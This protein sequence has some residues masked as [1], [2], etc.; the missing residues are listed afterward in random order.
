[1]HARVIA[2]WDSVTR[3]PLK[4]SGAGRR[5]TSVG[6]ILHLSDVHLGTPRGY[7]PIDEAKKQ[8]PGIDPRTQREVLEETLK[9]LSD[10]EE[11]RKSVDA[12]AL[13]GDIVFGGHSEEGYAEFPKFAELLL[14]FVDGDPS[15]LVV[16]PGNHD[17]PQEHGP[18]DPKRYKKFLDVTREEG[19]ATPLLDNWDF[20][21][22]GLLSEKG[23]KAPHLLKTKEFVIVPINT[24]HYC[25]GK[26]ELDEETFNTL[27]RRDSDK[28][29]TEAIEALLQH[30]IPRVSRRQM[31]ALLELLA[32]ED[33]VFLDPGE[34]DKRVRVAVLH[35]Q[36]LPVSEREE[37]KAFE[38]ITNLGAVRQFLADLGI[39][40]VLHGHKHEAALYWDYVAAPGGIEEP[41]RR[42]LISAAP[43]DFRPGNQAMRLLDFLRRPAARDVLIQDVHAPAGPAASIHCHDHRARLWRDSDSDRVADAMVVRDR[44]RDG[45][46]AKIQSLFAEL[47]PSTPLR[48]LICEISQ[49]EDLL[50]VPAGYPEVP[51]PHP[52][53]WLS[54]MVKWW[55]LPDPQL[56]AQVTF[57]HGN[58]IY[59]RFGDQVSRAA[60][61]LAYSDVGP[62]ST[63]RAIIVLVDPSKD[64]GRDGEFPSFTSMHFQ[65][66]WEGSTPRLDCTGYFRKQEMRYWWPINVAELDSVRE[67]VEEE[68]KK[69]GLTVAPGRLRTITGHAVAEEDLP[70]VALAMI[71][72]AIDQHPKDLWAMAD[73]LTRPGSK[74]RREAT[75]KL[76]RRYLDD[77][78]PKDEKVPHIKVSHQ[79][80]RT[81]QKE[82]DW[83]N[84]GS[85]H[86]REKLEALVGFYD[87]LIEQDS[88]PGSEVAKRAKAHLDD[89]C[90]AVDRDLGWRR[91]RRP[92]FMRFFQP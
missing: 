10:Q 61:A 24:S 74:K 12:V 86:S 42:M 5:L 31:H 65:L 68:L 43:G 91:F 71:D 17:V 58:R 11:V 8:V 30:D 62:R 84:G 49:P 14:R 90:S 29:R 57:N 25:W 48:D 9:R 4:T 54:D 50:S 36:L 81:I 7:Q 83:Q 70:A 18:E 39:E 59:R 88:G 75:R 19:F 51:G 15:R 78:Q 63:S 32:T 1:V 60:Q 37:F 13:S 69:R 38:S 89:L 76:W 27:Y 72:R 55:Q 45:A 46:Y 73:G 28:K 41:P 67:R 79:G 66:A 85:L 44:S 20:D 53:E 52:L 82:L 34:E 21:H 64:G 35:H 2:A 26:E 56:L 33:P 80:L 40:V 47:E 23:R 6:G 87:A 22:N 3:G 92:G 77:L 16:V